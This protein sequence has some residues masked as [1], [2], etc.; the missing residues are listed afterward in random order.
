MES[1]ENESLPP[2]PGMISSLTA[3][4]E[5]IANHVAAILL[6]VAFDLLLWLGPHLRV[7]TILKPAI[8]QWVYLTKSSGMNLSADTV[9]QTQKMWTLFAERFNILIILRTFP[10]GIPSLLA[11]QSPMSAPIGRPTIVEMSSFLSAFSVAVVLMV[12]GWIVGGM[13]F[14]W[15]SRVT[16]QRKVETVIT[17]MAWSVTQAVLL[18]ITWLTLLIIASIPAMI[19]I[20]IIPLI[21][22]TVGQIIYL[23]LGILVMWLL[24]PIYFSPHGI[25]TYG[26]NA[27][28]SILQSL[29][30]V[31]FTFPTTGL[32]VLIIVLIS[33]GL[34]F[35]WRTP[36]ES[37]WF[38]L[39]GVLGHAF[40]STAL[41]ASS[42]IYYRDM[43]SW[44]QVIL[45]RL[46]TQATSA[47]A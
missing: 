9:Q 26:Q 31:R 35:L 47:R 23:L 34:A 30:M 1:K 10:V 13:Y 32:F 43:N 42:F 33:Q 16:L 36:P 12:T 40:I 20:S 6:P 15:I 11:I 3:G 38:M 37:S 21:S 8:A 29:R 7:E 41:L 25:F 2:P 4:F 45:E 39:V 27:F 24:L 19:L 28:M 46:K 18:S 17:D 44:L 5:A 14:Y 22:P